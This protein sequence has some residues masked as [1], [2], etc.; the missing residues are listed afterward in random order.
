M[1]M[2]FQVI[3]GDLVN[4]VA[5]TKMERQEIRQLFEK[6]EAMFGSSYEYFLRGDGIQVL[7]KGNALTEAIY[8]TC[9]L[10]AKLNV[11]IRL[12]IGIGKIAYLSE[13]LSDSTGEAFI[14]S[15]QNLDAMKPN[16]N[17]ISVKTAD[18]WL[19]AE[20]EIHAKVLDYLE[21]SRSRNQ[22][23]VIVGLIENKTQIQLA[24]EIGIS[25]PS[26]NQRIKSSA[27]VLVEPILLRYE[28]CL[29]FVE[30]SLKH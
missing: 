30:T 23:E 19:N 24:E 17:S 22:S 9:L 8:L 18:P 27:W 14:I 5:L 6:C 1:P 20:W 25:Q 28:N 21:A 10:H 16:K 7:A 2:N 4:S 15:G 26:I 13:R 11:K 29:R 12:S 3:T